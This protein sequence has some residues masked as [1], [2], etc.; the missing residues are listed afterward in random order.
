MLIDKPNEVASTYLSI[1]SLLSFSHR[2]MAFFVGFVRGSNPRECGL[3]LIAIFSSFSNCDSITC[4][5]LLNGFTN[6]IQGYNDFLKFEIS[7]PWF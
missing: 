5:S 1:F 7:L 4:L 6:K 3:L 2:F